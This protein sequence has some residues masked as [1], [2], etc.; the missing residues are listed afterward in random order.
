MK[1]LY[2]LVTAI[3]ISF[4]LMNCSCSKCAKDYSDLHVHFKYD[5]KDELNTFEDY[6]VKDLV[7]DGITRT[8]LNFTDDEKESIVI[9]AEHVDFFNMPDTVYSTAE[10]EQEP[11]PGM[12]M[13]R[14]NL[15]DVDKT[16]YWTLPFGGSDDEQGLRKLSYHIRT[17]IIDKPEYK[18]LPPAKGGYL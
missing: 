11:L 6:F 14:L 9:M 5:Y 7:Q 8:T 4:T 2:L 18:E 1:K 16:V 12:Q 17:L 3:L 13:L 10:G 15:G